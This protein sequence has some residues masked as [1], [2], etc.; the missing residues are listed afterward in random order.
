MVKLFRGRNPI[1][2]RL[3]APSLHLGAGIA[4]RLCHIVVGV[5]LEV[6]LVLLCRIAVLALVLK[7]LGVVEIDNGVGI[8][9][10]DG[11]LVGGSGTRVVEYAHTL[12]LLEC[13]FTA[14]R[15]LLLRHLG[16][17]ILV[18]IPCL[19]VLADGVFFVRFLETG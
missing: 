8:V 6:Y 5:G 15:F 4:S 7:H 1:A 19:V 14:Q 10:L 18:H 9:V 17:D 11:V 13:H 2:R 3:L 16:V 12:P